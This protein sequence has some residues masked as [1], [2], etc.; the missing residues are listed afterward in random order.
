MNSGNEKGENNMSHSIRNGKSDIIQ[1]EP[2]KKIL[3]VG[4][5]WGTS[6]DGILTGCEKNWEYEICPNISESLSKL[7][8]NNYECLLIDRN[9]FDFL[10]VNTDVSQEKSVL[11]NLPV[12]LARVDTDFTIFWHNRQFGDWCSSKSGK[13]YSSL[14][15]LKF[16]EPLGH[17]E[18]QGP[19]YCPFK[20]VGETKRASNTS[21]LLGKNRYMTMNVIPI[22]GK[23]GEITSFLVE[24]RD[25]TEQRTAQQPLFQI[26][27][28]GHELTNLSKDD[29]LKLKPE[30]LRAVIKAKIRKSVTSILHYNSFE[31]R[32]LSHQTQL[33]LDPFLS[34]GMSEEASKRV[35]YARQ[36][37]NNGITGW[38]AFHGSSYRMDD[39]S[40]NIFYLEGI[41]GA[42]SSITVPL[43]HFGKIVGTFNVESQEPNAFSED[44]VRLLESYAEDVA[45][46]IATLDLLNFEQKDSAFKSIENVYSKAVSPLNH[47]LNECGRLLQGELS[48]V[49]REGLIGIQN[50]V[51]TIQHAFLAHVEEIRP[52]WTADT[53]S[54]VD[55]RNYEVLSGKRILLIDGD[56]Q[57]GQQLSKTLYFYGN[58]VET[59]LSGED[60]INMVNTTTYDA[61]ICNV[62]LGDMSSFTLFEQIR[63]II[64]VPFVPYIF[65]ASFGYDGGHVMVRAR[66]E[67]ITAFIYKPFKLPQLLKNLK[68]VL[69]EA[70]RQNP[71]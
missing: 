7:R 18:L 60:A 58:T 21:F 27:Q 46:A 64:K 31:I 68:T 49:V 10:Q 14:I 41:P 47:I 3:V 63:D 32:V 62:K 57:A 4:D 13:K 5:S 25:A 61:F 43:K 11:E 38:V 71:H 23:D 36:D 56:E 70:Q 2:S 20:T 9:Y 52:D 12:G 42:R 50:D 69:T 66:Q 40:E 34:V 55:C 39:R 1:S 30:E 35:L 6:G 51:R 24:I 22:F 33:L 37:N 15:G 8:Q 26:K 53:L 67:G 16:Y 29:V 45:I 17:P 59:A 44:D 48:D 54:E 19:D 65:M 28:A